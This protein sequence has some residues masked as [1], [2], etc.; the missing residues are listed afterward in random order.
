M[1]KKD[2]IVMALEILCCLVGGAPARI[3]LTI[4][5]NFVRARVDKSTEVVYNPIVR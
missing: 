3:A 1:K 5:K 4:I 2:I